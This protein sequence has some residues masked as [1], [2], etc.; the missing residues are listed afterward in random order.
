MQQRPAYL[1]H[2]ALVIG[3]GSY[4]QVYIASR[5]ETKGHALGCSGKRKK[6]ARM[7]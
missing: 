6:F 4:G 1:L 2:R 7:W 5:E 3:N